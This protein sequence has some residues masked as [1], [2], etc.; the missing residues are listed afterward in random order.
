MPPLLVMSPPLKLVSTLRRLTDG[1]S[2]EVWWR[3]VTAETLVAKASAPLFSS[4]FRR[5]AFR[6]FSIPFVKY[7]GKSVASVESYWIR[8]F[9]GLRLTWITSCANY[10]RYCN[11]CRTHA[12]RS[13]VTPVDINSCRWKKLCRGVFH[14]PVAA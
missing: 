5:A 13:G 10:Q 4:V 8:R 11:E 6:C 12:G 9:S 7:P 2:M 14:L 1:N 3:Y